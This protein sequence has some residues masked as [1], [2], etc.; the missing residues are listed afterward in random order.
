M[1]FTGGPIQASVVVIE[2]VTEMGYDTA[3][4][5]NFTNQQPVWKKRYAKFGTMADPGAVAVYSFSSLNR[6]FSIQSLW[7]FKLQTIRK[8]EFHYSNLVSNQILNVTGNLT[9][10][11]EIPTGDAWTK[12]FVVSFPNIAMHYVPVIVDTDSSDL[13][14]QTS[15]V[16]NNQSSLVFLV[17]F[18]NSGGA[19]V[20]SFE[21]HLKIWLLGSH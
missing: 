4:D 16:S 10:V 5:G 9:N 2:E 3:G 6:L 17:R 8:G 21:K 1:P 12:K 15:L 20:P 13:V 7:N 18:N 14:G 19:V 11:V